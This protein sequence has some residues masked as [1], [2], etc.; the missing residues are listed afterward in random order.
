MNVKDYQ[1]SIQR[2]L[3]M[4]DGS[5]MSKDEAIKLALVGILDEA[6]EI[7]G[8]LKK[9]FWHGH[10]MPL[11]QEMTDEIGDLLWYVFTLC[12]ALGIDGERAMDKNIEKLKRRY[13]DGFSSNNSINRNK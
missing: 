3:A 8:P 2:T 11:T 9:H 5:P 1:K 12:N 4:P 10:P 6:G 7:A 13:P